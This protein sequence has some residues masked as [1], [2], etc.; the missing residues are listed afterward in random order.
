MLN[1][2]I[3]KIH[4]D[5]AVR[6]IKVIYKSA[7]IFSKKGKEAF[8]IDSEYKKS[9]ILLLSLINDKIE[10]DY[11][12]KIL[13]ESI[14]GTPSFHF[15]VF[16]VLY[17]KKAEK[18]SF[19]NI[20]D[21]IKIEQLKN[22]LS[23]RLKKHF[24]DE[25]RDIFEE[26]PEDS[27]RVLVL[28]QWATNWETF[29]GDNKKTVSAYV[30][31]II[32]RDAKKFIKFITDFG[33]ITRFET[34]TFDIDKID[35]VCNLKVIYTL[36]EKFEKDISLSKEEKNLIDIFFRLYRDKKIKK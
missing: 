33:L 1:V 17:C 36:A 18:G 27:D 12:Q 8:F 5:T 10:K 13:E 19:F 31:S 14:A 21:A 28:D 34:K 30:I 16:V 25:N 7:N 20:Y 11:I 23:N 9:I 32:R 6:L 26:M 35:R 22:K 2:F 3:N 15:A 24:V 4:Q 29:T